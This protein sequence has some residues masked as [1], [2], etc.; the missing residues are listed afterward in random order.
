MTGVSGLDAE[1][2]RGRPDLSVV[3]ASVESGPTLDSA[4]DALLESA[5]GMAMEIIVVDASVDDSASRARQRGDPIRVLTRPV[6][7]LV[8]MLW[9]DGILRSSGKWVALTTGHCVVSGRWGEAVRRGF[10][11]GAAAIGS[12]LTLLREAKS[13]D[14]AVFFLRYSAYLKLLKGE[15]RVVDDLP[16]DNAVYQGDPVRSYASELD[17]RGFWELDYHRVL[18]GS[19]QTLWSEP[20]ATAGFG[21]SF[22]LRTILRHRFEHGRHFGSWRSSEGGE[23]RLRVL[24]AAPLVPFVFLAR[25]AVRSRHTPRL[26]APLASAALPLLA[27]AGAW[28][29]GEA[30]GALRPVQQRPSVPEAVHG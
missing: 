15:P 14:R 18:I 1:G 26:F 2:L 13:V 4:L 11:T 6:G 20:E 30:V 7:T 27:I 23:S 16:G 12:G 5:D 29:L 9:E 21:R 17:G 19:G 24:L 25:A 3:I 22:P 10:R 8:P 28:A